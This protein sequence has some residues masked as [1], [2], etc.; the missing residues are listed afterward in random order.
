MD[1]LESAR[2]FWNSEVQVPT[3]NSWMAHPLVR[4]YINQSI[5]GPDEGWPLD[6]FQKAYPGRRFRH[7]LS[8]GCGTG[9]LERDILARGICQTMD[10]VDASEVSLD[11]ARKEALGKGLSSRVNY[12]TADFRGTW[13]RRK[14]PR[15]DVSG[16]ASIQ[17]AR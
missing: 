16:P 1:E 3:H 13:I 12:F 4:E 15:D 10:A 5:S 11:I 2:R 9:A 14:H 7:G 17:V 6:W 8:I